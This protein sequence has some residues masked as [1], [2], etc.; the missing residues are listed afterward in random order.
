MIINKLQYSGMTQHLWK[1]SFLAGILNVI[2]NVIFIPIYGIMAAAVNTF[3]A[4]LYIGFSGYFLPIYKQFNIE[5]LYKPALIFTVILI[6][7]ILVYL[8]KDIGIMYKSFLT[9]I[10][11]CFYSIYLFKEFKKL[12][13]SAINEII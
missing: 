3:I 11:F 9:I 4:L 7:S 12:K 6:T 10:V 5:K 8:L 2:L 13:I 1:I